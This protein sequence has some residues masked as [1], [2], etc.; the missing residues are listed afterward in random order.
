[1]DVERALKAPL[2]DEGWVS[3]VLIGGVLS[4]VP[5]AGLITVGYALQVLDAAR[6]GERCLLPWEAWGAKFVSGLVAFIVTVVYFLPGTALLFPGGGWGAWVAC[7]RRMF[8]Y[9]SPFSCLFCHVSRDRLSC[10]SPPVWCCPWPWRTTWQPD[11]R[12]PPLP[13]A[14]SYA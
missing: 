1:M 5:I 12:R 14:A 6:R 11:G 9:R 7:F 13:F 10:P 4:L 8:P 2:E 3:K